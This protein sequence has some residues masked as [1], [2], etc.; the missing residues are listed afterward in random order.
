MILVIANFVM[1]L[2]IREGPGLLAKSKLCARRSNVC[3]RPWR[4]K[5]TV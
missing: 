5:N 4:V 1:A 2:A 3:G